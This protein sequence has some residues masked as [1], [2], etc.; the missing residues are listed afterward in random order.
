VAIAAVAILLGCNDDGSA[1]VESVGGDGSGF[2]SEAYMRERQLD[3]LRFATQSFNAGSVLNVVAHMERDRIDAGYAVGEEAVPVDAWDRLFDKMAALEDTR[4][5]DGLYLLNLLLGYGD[6]PMLPDEL[7]RKVEDALIAFKFWYTEPTPPGILDNSYYW[8]ENH[9]IIFHTIEYLMG[10]EYPDTVFGSDG[11]TGAVHLQHA[12]ALILRWIDH[13]ARFGFGEWHSNVYYQKNLT[14]LLTLVEYADDEGIRTRAA[15]LLDLLL[16]DMAM[17]TFRGAFG[18]T[19]G[20][21]YKKDKMTSLHD[22]TWNG[23]KLLFDTSTYEYQSTGAADAVLLARARRYRLPE[24]VRRAART[25]AAVVDRERMGI[26]IDEDGPWEE[27]PQAPYGFSFSDPDDLTIWWGMSAVTPWPVVPLTIRT[28]EDYNLWNTTNFAPFDGLRP[29]TTDPKLAQQLSINV[30]CMLNFALLKEVNTYTYRTA[31]Y[32]LSTVVD[33][34]KGCFGSQIHSWQATFDA[35]AVV[36]TT[37][38]FRPPLASTVWS[39][40]EEDGSYWTGEASIP[41]SAQF[42]NVAVHIYT[43]RYRPKNLSPFEYFRYELHTHAYFPQDHF[44]EVGREPAIETGDWTF[45]RFRDG[46]IALYSYRPTEWVAY[47]PE[48]YATNGMVLPFDLVAPGGPNNVWIVEV[49]SK[50][51]WGSFDAFRGAIAAS[52][53]DVTPLGAPSHWSTSFEVA[54]DSPSRGRVTFAWDAPFVVNGV[55]MPL[56]DFPRYDNPWAQTE[57]NTLQ[58]RIDVDGHGI[59]VDFQ[60]GTRVISA[61]R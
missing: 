38:P 42:E 20:R 21:S 30:N 22:D 18:V 11:K 34:R 28:L 55:E 53:V 9:Q 12:R 47:D 35:N 27:N 17:H 14:P 51:E 5:F 6:H 15:A 16:F 1:F 50:D 3:Y 13:R 58:T 4:D 32:L 39:D 61:P 60:R 49:G 44:D 41:R 54:Y 8:T 10:Q 29:F 40:D 57:L 19:H 56:A 2:V 31:D 7:V 45:G 52:R 59:E 37:H 36:F 43:P 25:E 33:Y 23:V 48:I 26:D 24:A 46:Y